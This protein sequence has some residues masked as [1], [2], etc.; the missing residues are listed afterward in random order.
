MVWS[1]LINSPRGP[2]CR[3]HTT[4]RIMQHCNRFR[5]HY[6]DA[7]GVQQ[8]QGRQVDFQDLLFGQHPV[9]GDTL[10]SKTGIHF[11]FGIQLI[12]NVDSDKF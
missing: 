12:G 9:S 1:V 8:L 2:T 10:R 5:V 11:H 4:I 3:C 6:L 7:D